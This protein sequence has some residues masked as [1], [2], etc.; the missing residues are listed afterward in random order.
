LR[1]KEL[2]GLIGPNGSGKTTLLNVIAGTIRPTSGSVFVDG[3]EVTNWPSHRVARKRV[4][5]TFQN[6]RLFGRLTVLENVEVGLTARPGGDSGQRSRKEAR[7][8]LDEV[9]IASRAARLA[10]TLPYGEQRR[11]EIARAVAG[12]PRYLL[13]DEPG[14]GMNPDESEGLLQMLS[15]IRERRGCGLL[16]VDHDLRLIM[17]LCERI[18]VL[19]EGRTIA[20][21]TP[22]EVQADQSVVQAYLGT[23]RG[24]RRAKR[25]KAH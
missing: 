3:D 8:V 17:G 11:V 24:E 4:A 19:N 7:A 15:G 10:G 25:G 20:E 2:L 13:L 16:V 21:G 5:R 12:E 23:R 6:I 14:A 9:G 1:G 22:A 18:H